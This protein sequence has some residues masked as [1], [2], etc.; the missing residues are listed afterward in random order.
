MKRLILLLIA[1]ALAVPQTGTAK[2]TPKRAP[3]GM[4][5][6]EGG[7]YRPLYRDAATGDQVRV[8]D[9]Y[10]DAYPVTN[11]DY[12]AFVKANPEWQRSRV[13]RLF[14]DD[15]YLQHWTGDLSFDPALANRPVVNVSWFAAKAYAEWKGKR[16][17]TTAEWEYVAKA[18]VSS[19]DGTLEPGYTQRLML[20]YSR[21]SGRDLPE[22]GSTFKNYWGVYDLHGVVWEWVYDFNTALVTG[23]SRNNTDLDLARFCGSATLGANDFT[24]YTAFLR[25]GFRSG[26]EARFTVPNLGFRLA[27]DA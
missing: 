4:V 11:A 18:G 10:L 7:T 21:R 9:F 15:T 16:L 5:R 20:L 23:E 25:F 13:K 17:P 19:R 26:L 6:V 24:D 12:L 3:E 27:A 14:A 8:G 1:V 22:V 2:E